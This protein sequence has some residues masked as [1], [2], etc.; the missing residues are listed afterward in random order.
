M[1]CVLYNLFDS[2]SQTLVSSW[3]PS[4][5]PKGIEL[6]VDP[7]TTLREGERLSLVCSLKSSNPAVLEYQWWKNNQTIYEGSKGSRM[8]IDAVGR[9][10]SGNYK[11]GA[12]NTLGIT[13]SEELAINIQCEWIH[14]ADKR[15]VCTVHYVCW[16]LRLPHRHILSEFKCTGYQ[17]LHLFI[18]QTNGVHS[19]R[20]T[21]VAN[22][23]N[24]WTAG[25]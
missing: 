13:E 24:D 19:M 6:S 16:D 11:C 22:C 25:Y 7:G 1:W 9:Q 21:G 14:G 12:R 4:D 3:L 23:D 15:W 2:F 5:A 8:E 20:W 10:H 18:C 17:L